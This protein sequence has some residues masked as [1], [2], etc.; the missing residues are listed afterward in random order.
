VFLIKTAIIF[1][2]AMWSLSFAPRIGCLYL[3]SKVQTSMSEV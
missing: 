2:Q 3:I 1:F